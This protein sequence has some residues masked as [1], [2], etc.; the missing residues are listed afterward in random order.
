MLATGAH[1]LTASIMCDRQLC[2]TK[3]QYLESSYREDHIRS[4]LHARSKRDPPETRLFR[5]LLHC[6][7][8]KLGFSTFCA[9]S[10][11]TFCRAIFSLNTVFVIFL[12]A[13]SWPMSTVLQISHRGWLMC[14]RWIKYSSRRACRTCSCNN[15]EINASVH[16]RWKEVVLWASGQHIALLSSHAPSCRRWS[17]KLWP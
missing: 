8:T 13:N 15:W 9:R 5:K 6:F 14:K 17:N 4:R 12:L 7:G 10:S 3:Y 11:F 2:C 16:I 1:A